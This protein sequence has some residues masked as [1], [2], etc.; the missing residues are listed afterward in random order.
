MASG[1]K[2]LVLTTNKVFSGRS[3]MEP[4]KPM[5]ITKNGHINKHQ[6]TK[7]TERYNLKEVKKF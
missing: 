3:M 2:N 4:A 5:I 1:C 6:E 7:K